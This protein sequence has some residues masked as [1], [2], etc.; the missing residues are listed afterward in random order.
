[1]V[2]KDSYAHI[3]SQFLCEEY[4]EVHFLDPRYTNFDYEDYITENGIT[5]VMFLYNVSTF[6]KDVSIKN[7]N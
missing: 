1:M 5:D 2:I 4:S 6:E 3:M 7:I